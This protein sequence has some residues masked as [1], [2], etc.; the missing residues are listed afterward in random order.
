MTSEETVKVRGLRSLAGGEHGGIQPGEVKEIPA[1]LAENGAGTG[2]VQTGAVEYVG[3]DYE[4]TESQETV[5]T[6]VSEEEREEW[7]LQTSPA[8]Y[9]ER[10]GGE[11]D[12]SETVENRLD[13]ARELVSE[14]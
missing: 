10:Y 3:S 7:P 14:E 11:E 4:T 8:E 2:W 6:T 12:V 1:S 13:L 5:E 9:L